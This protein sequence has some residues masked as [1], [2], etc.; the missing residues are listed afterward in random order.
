MS[1][2]PSYLNL[3]DKKILLV[4]GGYIALE[5]LEKL[6][7]FTTDI[8]V[9]SKEVS[10]DFLEFSK[11]YNIEIEKRAYRKG[12]I[13]SFDIVVVATDTRELH[14][15]IYQESRNSR[16]LVNSV[17]DTA[18]CDFI[19]PSYIKQGDLTISISTSGA[20][21][22][23]AKRI[24]VYIEKVIPPNIGKFLKEMKSLRESMPKGKERMKFFE[25]KSDEFMR[26]YFKI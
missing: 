19:F 4:G 12:D 15:E 24:R 23:M 9:I 26:R 25:K 13:D 11:R 1:F 17:D 21:P 16:V 2:F 8:K 14:R 20:S 7:D 22:A 10:D 3:K 5:K 6:T 18:Y